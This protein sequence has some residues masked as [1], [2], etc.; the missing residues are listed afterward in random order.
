MRGAE[1]GRG[2]PA[3]VPEGSHEGAGAGT[4]RWRRW[5]VAALGVV[6]GALFVLRLTGVLE[7]PTRYL[8]VALAV[9]VLL[10]LVEIGVVIVGARAFVAAR[11]RGGVLD[12][13]EAWIDAE[14]R[15]G[16]PR[17]IIALMQL[18]L[19]LYRALA[20]ARARRGGTA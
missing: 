2:T 10:A 6:V 14:R 16:L 15:L 5:F 4:R 13:Y 18:E 17:P 3:G 19:R 1:R 11:R 8:V 20:R 12:G 9:D 7:I